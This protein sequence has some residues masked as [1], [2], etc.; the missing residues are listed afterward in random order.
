MRASFHRLGCTVK[1]ADFRTGGISCVGR[2][3]FT[4]L[5]LCGCYRLV[6]ACMIRRARGVDG[7]GRIGFA[8][9]VCVYERCLQHGQGLHPPSIIGLVRGRVLPVE[10]KHQSPQG[11][12]P[13]TSMDFLC[14]MTWPFVVV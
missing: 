4:Q 7:G 14:E 6:A 5:A 1:L 10:P 11:I 13:R 8:V 9:T 12:G 2:R 3:V